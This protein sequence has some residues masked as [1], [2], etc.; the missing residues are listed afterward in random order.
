M[1]IEIERSFARIRREKRLPRGPN[2]I[3]VLIRWHYCYKSYYG[4]CI[5]CATNSFVNYFATAHVA[6]P[7][8]HEVGCA[9]TFYI[10]QYFS[11]SGHGF[12]Q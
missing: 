1:Q 5:N 4:Y 7:V 10:G 3:A 6:G 2:L 9:E 8:V 11:I 12:K